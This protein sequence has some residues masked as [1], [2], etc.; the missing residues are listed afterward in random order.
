VIRILI[1]DD[2]P[3]VLDALVQLFALERDIEVVAR[4]TD[5]DEALALVT[6]LTPDVAVLDIRMGKR[7]GMSV[8]REIVGRSLPT[9]VVLLTAQ[10]SDD[11]VLEA[12]SLGVGSI[13]L[14]ETASR[15]IV[16]A[17]RTVAAGEHLMDEH[18]VR[19]ALD[20][21]LRRE[22]GVAAARR[23][24]TAREI[25]IVRMVATGMRNKAIADALNIAEGT[26][27]IHLHSIYEKLGVTGRVELTLYA[28]E[29]SLT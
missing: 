24:L 5:G 3:I 20:R 6:R 25:E 8:L 9:R 14:K 21:M 26:V 22:A 10:M 17:V 29:K 13:V 23:V 1:A 18:V 2:H 15:R 19:R 28:Q 11:E 7:D 4:C 16:Q 12:V 27:K